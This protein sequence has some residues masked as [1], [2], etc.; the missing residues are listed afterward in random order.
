MVLINR[1]EIFKEGVIYPLPFFR[2][3][4]NE[5]KYNNDKILKINF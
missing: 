1:L 2:S 3:A 4:T 5:G